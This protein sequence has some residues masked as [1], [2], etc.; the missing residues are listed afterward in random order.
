MIRSNPVQV[1]ASPG[2]VLF[3]HYVLAHSIGG[4]TSDTARETVYMRLSRPDNQEHWREIVADS[5]YEYDG[6]RAVTTGTSSARTG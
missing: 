4:N 2:D 1:R 6:V 3:A 5:W